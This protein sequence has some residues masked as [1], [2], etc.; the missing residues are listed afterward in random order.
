MEA[1]GGVLQQLGG[2]VQLQHAALG[3]SREQLETS[4]GLADPPRQPQWMP[5]V[6]GRGKIKN[7]LTGCGWTGLPVTLQQAAT[8]GHPAGHKKTRNN[9]QP[10]FVP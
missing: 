9:M 4:L 6:L 1:A 8:T 10:M 5:S 3:D 2:G 7:G